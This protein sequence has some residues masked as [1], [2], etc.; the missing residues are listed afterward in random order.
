MY[1]ED[2]NLSLAELIRKARVELGYL[3]KNLERDIVDDDILPRNK[4]DGSQNTRAAKYLMVW[5]KCLYTYMQ[6]NGGI[7]GKSGEID[8][9]GGLNKGPR[10][11]QHKQALITALGLAKQLKGSENSLKRQFWK[12]RDILLDDDYCFRNISTLKE[13]SI[14]THIR[15]IDE[16]VVRSVEYYKD[17]DLPQKTI[18][19]NFYLKEFAKYLACYLC[20]IGNQFFFT[21]KNPKT[22]LKYFKKAAQVIAKFEDYGDHK[23]LNI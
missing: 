5:E 7:S 1:L 6:Q 3:L 22:A 16:L 10:P 20:V 13:L 21:Y 9:L 12:V 11:G 8:P 23:Y 19:L 17:Y 2:L 15:K 4:I 18:N 14:P